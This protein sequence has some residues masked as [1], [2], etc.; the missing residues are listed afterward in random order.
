MTLPCLAS[1]DTGCSAPRKIHSAL[2]GSSHTCISRLPQSVGVPRHRITVCYS[3][4]SSR[5][6]NGLSLVQPDR[7]TAVSRP[8][9]GQQPSLSSGC[10]SGV[11]RHS[12][13]LHLTHFT[14]LLLS[15]CVVGVCIP[16][17]QVTQARPNIVS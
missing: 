3:W 1:S 6:T 8:V 13:C 10:C 4:H 16:F 2:R 11:E 17:S 5:A 12:L 7:G 9:L 15:V 14:C